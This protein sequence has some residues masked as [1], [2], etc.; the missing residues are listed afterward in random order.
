MKFK[1]VTIIDQFP[2]NVE[3]NSFGFCFG[4]TFDKSA[5]LGCC[6]VEKEL[7]L[8]EIVY[9][10]DHSSV[11]EKLKS[12]NK[13]AV[14]DSAE[15]KLLY[16]LKEMGINIIPAKKYKGLISVI[17]SMLEECNVYVTKDSQNLIKEL[18]PINL[19][20]PFIDALYGW[21]SVGIK[22][23]NFI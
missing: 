2:E 12:E 23:N 10:F 8:R 19:Q 1:T 6:I 17:T 3:I 11:I 22:L 18:E 13:I 7:Y 21:C 16:D 14:V 20:S 9:S 5:I 4:Y 15:P